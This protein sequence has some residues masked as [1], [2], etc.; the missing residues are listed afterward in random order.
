MKLIESTYTQL[1]TAIANSAK[2]ITFLDQERTRIQQQYAEVDPE[3]GSYVQFIG[4]K[5]VD[6]LTLAID[7]L[8]ACGQSDHELL[9]QKLNEP[10][11]AQLG[12]GLWKQ[13][14]AA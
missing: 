2:Q 13:E 3:D 1:A 12:L 7:T 8:K 11:E 10:V 6:S 5:L 14:T 9:A 4:Q